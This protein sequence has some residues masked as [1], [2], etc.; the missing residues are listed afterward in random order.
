[1]PKKQRFRS[2][3]RI[4]TTAITGWTVTAAWQLISNAGDTVIAARLSTN[5]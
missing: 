2:R 4:S 5:I 3:L 1:M